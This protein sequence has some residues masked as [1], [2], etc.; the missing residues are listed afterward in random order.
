MSVKVKRLRYALFFAVIIFIG[1]CSNDGDV[2]S[3]ENQNEEPVH[4][5]EITEVQEGTLSSDLSLSGNVMASKQM[6]VLPMLTGEVIA[7]HVKNGDKVE[8]GD[9]LVELDATDMELNVAQA[10]AGLEAAEASLKSAKTMRE[11]SIKQA[12]MQ[13]DQAKDVHK[14]VSEAQSENTTLELE[15]VPEE[16]QQVFQSL[17]MGNM[18]TEQDRAQAESAVNQAEMALEQ[19]KGTDQIAAAEASVKQ[20][21]IGVEMAQQQQTHAV[22]SAPISGQI[23]NFNVVVGE[24]VS[25]QSPLLQLVQMDE[26]IV[27]LDVN[28]S[29]LPSIQLDQEVSVYIPTFNKRYEGTVT[30]I[31]IMPGEQSRAYPVEIVLSEPEDNLRIGML[32]NV[33]FNTAVTNEQVLVPVRAVTEQSGE[34]SVFVTTDGEQVER[35]VITI[36]NESPEFYEII[37]GVEIGE[38]VVINGVHQLYDG[39]KVNVRNGEDFGFNE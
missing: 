8:K 1:G 11:Q 34:H 37:D 31:G 14:M 26:P 20:A 6:A 33:M 12:Q 21:R 3:E 18:P 27:R 22:V 9:T 16:L 28:E 17:L 10:R 39:A 19:A 2:S 30:H 5:V 25:P 32:A 7:V 35:R 15:E 36:G 29:M 24:M 23:S 4:P 13:L 38:L